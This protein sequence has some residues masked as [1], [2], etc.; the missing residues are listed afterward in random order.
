MWASS[1]GAT[2]EAENESWEVEVL[3]EMS[4]ER[5]AH[6]PRDYQVQGKEVMH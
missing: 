3:S 2:K 1:W 4:V 5:A 6:Q